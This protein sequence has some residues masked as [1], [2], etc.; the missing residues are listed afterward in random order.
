MRVP[1]FRQSLVTD[2]F[3]SEYWYSLGLDAQ[4]AATITNKSTHE[5]ERNIARPPKRTHDRTPVGEELSLLQGQS[6]ARRLLNEA[7]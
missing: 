5:A 1:D 4:P 3:D 7:T 6:S 2:D